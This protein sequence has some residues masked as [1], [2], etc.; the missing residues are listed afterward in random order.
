MDQRPLLNREMNSC[1]EW[2]DREYSVVELEQI[3]LFEGCLDSPIVPSSGIKTYR[4]ERCFAKTVTATIRLK[5]VISVKG[6]VFCKINKSLC[7]L[8]R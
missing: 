8:L 4:Q 1:E 2:V 6:K 7:C 3:G 5:T